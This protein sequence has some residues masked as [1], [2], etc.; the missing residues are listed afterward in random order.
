MQHIRLSRLPAAGGVLTI[1][2]TQG[3]AAVNWEEQAQAL[4]ERE[5]REAL[6]AQLPLDGEYTRYQ[7]AGALRY[8]ALLLAADPTQPRAADATRLGVSVAELAA[9]VPAV[10]RS[11]WLLSYY[12]DPEGTRLLSR[13]YLRLAS[14]Y[15][16]EEATWGSVLRVEPR[17]PALEHGV[18]YAPLGLTS[19]WLELRLAV[20]RGGLQRVLTTDPAGLV[21]ALL[22][23]T[24]DS[25]ASTYG[26][27]PGAGTYVFTELQALQ[28]RNALAPVL[29]QST[30]PVLTRYQ[31]GT[32]AGYVPLVKA[33]EF[34]A[35]SPI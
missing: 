22:P 20:A 18:L 10:S 1:P 31:A 32:S 15:A 13:N 16:L 6:A 28:A 29:N 21:P 33:G 9:H 8:E 34:N 12:A 2:L 35:T 17:V 14:A 5:L 25:V 30:T 7:P 27:T 11:L 4:A 3:N 19:C 26:P 23:L 24:L